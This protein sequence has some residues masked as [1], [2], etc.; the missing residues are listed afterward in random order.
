MDFRVSMEVCKHCAIISSEDCGLKIGNTSNRMPIKRVV[1]DT[2]A[3][4]FTRNRL[5]MIAIG[6][7]Q[8]YYRIMGVTVARGLEPFVTYQVQSED[9]CFP[10]DLL[11]CKQGSNME[12]LNQIPPLSDQVDID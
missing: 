11:P 9:Y 12:F 1:F 4:D 10:Q 7:V 5:R 3:A 6:M 2:T 8:D